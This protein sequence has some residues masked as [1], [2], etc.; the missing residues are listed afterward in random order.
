MYLYSDEV[1]CPLGISQYSIHGECVSHDV[2]QC[3]PM[4]QWSLSM[5][6]VSWLWCACYWTSSGSSRM[7]TFK[8]QETLSW[9]WFRYSLVQA[10]FDITYTSVRNDPFPLSFILDLN[11]KKYRNIYKYLTLE[12]CEWPIRFFRESRDILKSK[13]ATPQLRLSQRIWFP[14]WS[15]T[16]PQLLSNLLSLYS[17]WLVSQQPNLCVAVISLWALF[18]QM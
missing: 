13:C 12:Y 7:L 8:T 15:F 11:A 3:V 6:T 17:H 10:Y 18:L 2:G 9:C 4:A 1:W 16:A 5:L 14:A